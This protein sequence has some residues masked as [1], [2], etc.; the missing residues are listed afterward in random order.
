MN[1]T[2]RCRSVPPR[3]P[4]LADDATCDATEPKRGGWEKRTRRRAGWGRQGTAACRARQRQDL[5][6][7]PY[8]ARAGLAIHGAAVQCCVARARDADGRPPTTP[9]ARHCPCA[10]MAARLL[11]LLHCNA[12]TGTVGVRKFSV[13]AVTGGSI[14]LCAVRGSSSSL[15]DKYRARPSTYFTSSPNPYRRHDACDVRVVTWSWVA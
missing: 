4:Q 13:L 12:G 8:R 6:G 14:V 1:T 9:H 15:W 11:S 3:A 10:G 2:V 5:S 7:R